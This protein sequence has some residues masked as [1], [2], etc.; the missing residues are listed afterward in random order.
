[1]F[2]LALGGAILT[3]A[4]TAAHAGDYNKWGGI[5]VGM[6]AGKIGSD[7]GWTYRNP[8][9]GAQNVPLLSQEADGTILGG[10]AGYQHQ[11]GNFVV[12]IEGAFG[13]L[14]SKSNFGATPCTNPAFNCEAR[15]DSFMT[16][17]GRLGWT[18]A[19]KLLLFVSG[20]AASLSVKT[21][22][23]LVAT[24]AVNQFST[25]DRHNGWYIGAGV[26][27]ALTRN[28]IVGLEYQHLDLGTKHHLTVG[29]PSIEDR[30]ISLDADVVRAR[31]SFKL[32]H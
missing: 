15:P 28:W 21:Q 18:P 29:T 25:S 6:N 26:E 23:R 17:G 7:I 5:Y 10:H 14:A 3:G 8:A 32:G 1:M 27:Y 9:T 31:L 30:R 11:I 12:G 2:G 22:E 20:G 19:D 24:G 16:L 4:V 13:G